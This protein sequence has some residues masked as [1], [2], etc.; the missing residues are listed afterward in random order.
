MI[1]LRMGVALRKSN[2][3]TLRSLPVVANRSASAYKCV[4]VCLCVFECVCMCLCVFECVCVR[5]CVQIKQGHTAITAGC[6]EQVCFSL[7]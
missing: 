3:A 1:I 2:R 6:C 5:V 4:C 7:Q